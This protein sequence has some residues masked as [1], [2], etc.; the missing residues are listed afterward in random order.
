MRGAHCPSAGRQ[1]PVRKRSIRTPDPWQARTRRRAGH[2]SVPARVRAVPAGHHAHAAHYVARPEQRCR[3]PHAQDLESI[4]TRQLGGEVGSG[5]P[6]LPL[7]PRPQP[8][9]RA[10]PAPPV[11]HFPRGAHAPRGAYVHIEQCSAARRVAMRRSKAWKPSKQRARRR[12]QSRALGALPRA[13]APA[14]A[15]PTR[16]AA[17]GPTA[18]RTQRARLQFCV[19]GQ[20]SRSRPRMR[21]TPG[22]T[23]LRALGSTAGGSRPSSARPRRGCFRGAPY[24]IPVRNYRST[25][26]LPGWGAMQ[27]APRIRRGWP[28]RQ[29]HPRRD[30]LVAAW[31]GPQQAA[32]LAGKMYKIPDDGQQKTHPRNHPRMLNSP[33]SLGPSKCMCT[34]ADNAHASRRP[35]RGRA[36]TGP[37][38]GHCSVCER[39]STAEQCRA[40]ARGQAPAAAPCGPCGV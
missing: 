29:D 8:Q 11:R 30:S 9:G 35:R 6:R 17:A 40:A 20:V 34:D 23:K 13:G 26:R 3:P 15:R 18:E 10:A 25:W 24:Q 33:S 36:P 1:R 5:R 31:P 4:T 12:G 14:V 39:P 19:A 28:T 37:A 27:L 16:A 38:A 7:P 2:R 22:P 21:R 32:S